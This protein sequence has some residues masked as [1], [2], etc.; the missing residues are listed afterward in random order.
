[1][2]NAIPVYDLPDGSQDLGDHFISVEAVNNGDRAVTITGWGIRL[3]GDRRVVVT[4]PVNWST[5]LPHRL[6]PGSA[7]AAFRM[8]ADELRRLERD[9]GIPY[10]A[11]KPYVTLADGTEIAADRSVPLA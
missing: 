7:P 5:P 4:R 11:M 10:D 3:P 9:Q 8:P 2:T 6:E 1:V